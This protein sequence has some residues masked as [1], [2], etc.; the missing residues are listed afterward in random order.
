MVV[1]GLVSGDSRV[2]KTARSAWQ[3]GYDVTVIGLAHR[4]V[5]W[6][7]DLHGITV[8]R[9][10]P[11]YSLHN[12]W[13]AESGL[14]GTATVSEQT[15]LAALL[16]SWERHLT[17]SG[18][19]VGS[20]ATRG[21]ARLVQRPGATSRP[22]LL[23]LAGSR[24]RSHPSTAPWRHLF[25]YLVDLEAAFAEAL[26]ELEPDLIHVHDAHPLPAAAYASLRRGGDRQIPWL[27]DAHEFVPGVPRPDAAQ[28]DAWVDME[29]AFIG[30][31]PAVVTVSDQVA[32]ELKARHR[33]R[34]Y[35]IVVLNAPSNEHV[36]M[37]GRRDIRAEVGVAPEVPLL[38]YSGALAHRR[39]VHTI[40][41]ALPRLP[42]VHL[43]VVCNPAATTRLDLL[44]LAAAGG[45]ADRLHFLPY[46]QPSSVTWYL[47]TATVGVVPLLHTPAHELAL[48]TKVFEYLHAGLPVIGSDV[49]TMAS[50]L[51]ETSVGRTFR[52]EDVDDLVVTLQAA[53][54]DIDLLK[55][56]ISRE[57]LETYSWEGQ[58]GGLLA[59]YRSLLDRPDDP[60]RDVMPPHSRPRLGVG[61]LGQWLDVNESIRAVASTSSTVESIAGVAP[62]S[63]LGE[64]LRAVDRVRSRYDAV[65]IESLTPLFGPLV[66]NGVVGEVTFLRGARLRAGLLLNG[67][68]VRL[69]WGDVHPD[70]WPQAAWKAATRATFIRQVR[71][72]RRTLHR[73]PGVPVL[74]SSPDV[75]LEVPGLEWIPLA[76]PSDAFRLHRQWRTTGTPRVAYVRPG[77]GAPAVE[78]LLSE[79]AAL[80]E[81]GVLELE[82]IDAGDP[83]S[84]LRSLKGFDALVDHSIP[85][86]FGAA[87]I[88]AM[89]AGVPVIGHV[90]G[91][92]RTLVGEPP[93]VE[94]G[95]EAAAGAVCDVVGDSKRWQE[96]SDE[97]REFAREVHDGTSTWD[98]LERFVR[99]A[100][101]HAD[102]DVLVDDG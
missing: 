31:A 95:L 50:F 91:D 5:P 4:T 102:K 3:A 45:V 69:S 75:V 74:C 19:A 84:L 27:Y 61:P 51:E 23:R 7:E 55:A 70:W 37:P 64:R 97:G 38:V 8:Y 77:P 35:P 47:S 11:S 16:G 71:A 43:A 54:R 62:R 89:A 10:S 72:N 39:G 12:L 79:F 49:R 63:T 90:H 56:A 1:G 68:E 22:R 94:T 76:L 44:R 92:V 98:V 58:V 53:L 15:R 48:A 82:V 42:G 41:E 40:V 6:I 33:L 24:L 60:G 59:V 2:E 93:I 88:I 14:P 81:A 21:A 36:P 73:L 30:Q 80:E 100:A 18:H 13:M 83:R 85:G 20:A 46:V 28:H 66:P 86:A 78:V 26:L 29:A 87:A 52:A 67:P 101:A 96:A 17:L 32:R 34:S 9:I 25:P 57:L 99:G 65:L